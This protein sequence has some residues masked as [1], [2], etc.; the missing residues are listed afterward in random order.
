MTRDVSCSGIRA[1]NM[2]AVFLN[3]D[4]DGCSF[5]ICHVGVSWYRARLLCILGRSVTESNL[6]QRRLR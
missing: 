2:T 4:D 5:Y 3:D 6:P 1:H